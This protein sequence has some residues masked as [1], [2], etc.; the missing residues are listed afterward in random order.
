MTIADRNEAEKAFLEGLTSILA[1]TESYE[2]GVNNPNVGEIVQVGSPRNLCV[3]LQEFGH[4]ARK[5]GVIANAYLF[6]NKPM[7]DKCLGLWLK[8]SLESENDAA[9]EA[10]KEEIFCTYK[11]TW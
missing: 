2:L 4:A 7:D 6:F 1:A 9:H 8:S 5:E 3:L 10:V 11:K